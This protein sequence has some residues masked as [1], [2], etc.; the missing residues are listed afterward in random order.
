M[1]LGHKIRLSPT[2]EQACYFQRAAGTARFVYNWALEA[3]NRQYAAG[4][5]P[6]AKALKKQFNAV[7]YREFPWLV[8][9][10][11]DSHAQPFANLASAWS[12]Y[13]AALKKGEEAHK[14]TFKR[15]RRC[16]DSFYV[17][18]DKLTICGRSVRLPKVGLVDMT[19]ELR[20]EGKLVAATVS[21]TA[22]HWYI[23]IQ[24][25]MPDAIAHRKRTAHGVIGVDLGITT[26]AA[27]STGELIESPRPLRAALRRIRV[28]SRR[29]SRKLEFAKRAVGFAGKARMPTGVRLPVSANRT[30]AYRAMARLHA[31]VANTRSDFLH[32]LTTRLCRENQAIG[33]EDLNVKGMLKND[34]LAR[35]ISDIGFWMFRE[36]L[37]Y[38]AKRY[39]TTLV[40]ADRWFPSSRLCSACGWKN[41][42]LTLS[43]RRW[44]CDRCQVEHHRDLNAS[45]NLEWLATKTALPVAS[46]SGNGGTTA[47]KLGDVGGKVTSVR[48]ESGPYDV[49]GQK[50]GEHICAPSQ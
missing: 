45:K 38:K 39:G 50:E 17:A 9:L 33:I 4:E 1:I 29:A 5:R 43:Q 37:T 6:T 41:S 13:F 49:S 10:H 21:R 30:K 18:N 31:D 44:R 23:A 8:D 24:V 28:R 32:K 42:G 46:S 20:L 48:Y 47:Q 36:Q 40:V 11:R 19:E 7:K 26:A 12:Q 3:W 14:P 22:D 35:H 34:R 16:Q 15:K 2:P 27:L 25:D